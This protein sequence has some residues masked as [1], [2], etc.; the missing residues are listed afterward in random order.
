M[1][2]GQLKGMSNI[3]LQEYIMCMLE[4]NVI[5]SLDNAILD[6]YI[7]TDILALCSGSLWLKE[8]KIQ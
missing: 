2:K 8:N 5:N 1:Q 6:N 7:A 4:W 3:T